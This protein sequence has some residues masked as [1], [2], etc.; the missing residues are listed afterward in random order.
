M[1]ALLKLRRGR[2]MDNAVLTGEEDAALFIAERVSRSSKLHQTL[3]PLF[4]SSGK[5]SSV[6]TS[7][8]GRAATPHVQIIK[9]RV[10]PVQTSDWG[11]GPMRP[12]CSRLTVAGQDL[13]ASMAGSYDLVIDVKASVD[14]GLLKSGHPGYFF[15]QENSPFAPSPAPARIRVARGRTKERGGERVEDV[16]P[17]SYISASKKNDGDTSK[18]LVTSETPDLLPR[19]DG[20]ELVEE[21]EEA[22]YF[23]TVVHGSREDVEIDDIV[24]RGG[25]RRLVNGDESAY[26]VTARVPLESKLEPDSAP[27]GKQDGGPSAAPNGVHMA[28]ND[29]IAGRDRSNTN[30]GIAVDRGGHCMYWSNIAQGRWV[31]DDD[32][33]LS[34]GVLAVTTDA[35]PAD[36][37]CAFPL[38]SRCRGEISSSS[39]QCLDKDGGREG[40]DGVR[41]RKHNTERR[42]NSCG[43][44]KSSS[45]SGSWLLDAPR[46]QTWVT[47]EDVRVECEVEWRK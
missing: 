37:S 39:R 13:P 26:A 33:D 19:R 32:L 22:G 44:S 41:S 12:P 27:E 3:V 1:C 18:S 16:P 2:A 45:S 43:R 17:F 28:L 35:A 24:P 15:C 11:G 6:I 4:P 34:N 9:S 21:D 31:L 46:L 5:L 7:V 29:Q 10:T 20:N 36:A 14:G 25:D 38:S 23:V 42:N 40:L 8:V 30:G 47:A